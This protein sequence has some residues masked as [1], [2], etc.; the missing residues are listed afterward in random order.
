M[1][2]VNFK[3]FLEFR[4]RRPEEKAML[5]QFLKQ[6]KVSQLNLSQLISYLELSQYLNCSDEENCLLEIKKNLLSFNQKQLL[7]L[8]LL[9]FEDAEE[10][11]SE[12]NREIYIESSHSL[13][14]SDVFEILNHDFSKEGQVL[15]CILPK[16]REKPGYFL[17]KNSEGLWVKE[18]DELWSLPVL[19]KSSRKLSFFQ[20]NGDTPKGLFRLN[21]IMPEANKQK[22][23]GKYHRVKVDFYLNNERD[24]LSLD[25][26]LKRKKALWS[27]SYIASL[28][29]R[30]LL[31][32]H[33]TGIIN[34]EKNSVSWPFIKTSGC[35]TT[36]ECESYPDDQKILLSMLSGGNKE[37][38]SISGTLIVLESELSRSE[39]NQSVLHG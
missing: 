10:H 13:S 28:F 20:K 26:N 5:N 27:Q 12:F 24:I 25:E 8:C 4:V 21:S 36:R 1:K 14:D 35:L 34:Q 7:K 17:L 16:N 30:S 15:F 38:S 29:E 19:A 37:Y 22:L 33:G 2:N 39:A 18:G 9:G 31:R 6:Q 3:N 32:I 23:F 11:L